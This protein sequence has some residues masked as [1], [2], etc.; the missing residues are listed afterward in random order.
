MLH[1]DYNALAAGDLNKGLVLLFHLAHFLVR[2]I[3]T[4]TLPGAPAYTSVPARRTLA[5][6]EASAPPTQPSTQSTKPVKVDWSPEVRA[7]VARAFMET[8]SCPGID[9]AAITE[10][11]K[12]ILTDAADNNVLHTINWSTYILPQ[13]M[14]QAERA[15]AF[16]MSPSHAQS[17]NNMAVAMNGTQISSAKKR[18]SSDMDT[19]TTTN[20]SLPPWRLKASANLA[21]R[22]TIPEKTEKRQKKVD[23]L[24]TGAPTSKSSDLEKRRQRFNLENSGPSSP[25]FTSSR[26][27]SPMPDAND[28]PVVGTCQKM[29]KNYFRLTAP[30]K[31]E[32]VRPLPV[33]KK[34]L[35][36]L[37]LKWKQE[38]NYGYVCD[39]FKSIR[40]DLTVQH[41]K[42]DFTVKVYESHA[43][44]ALERAD[45]GE[46]NQ[47][48]TQ[49]RALYKQKL[50]GNVE[51]F[52]AYRILY[53]IYTRNR[54]G[55]NDVL[56]DL[57]T[58]DKQIPAVRH[59]LDVRSALA[60][61]NFHRF[62]R[63]FTVAPNMGAYLI[64]T[65]IERERLAA[66][67]QICKA[68]VPICSTRRTS[69]DTFSSYK[70]QVKVEYLTEELAF[71][72]D[73]HCAQFLCDHGGEALL[74]SRPDGACF[75]SG[76][77]GQIF[78]MAK[79]KAFRSVDIKGQI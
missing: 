16:A 67:A 25:Y 33:L 7:Y 65:F 9:K 47:C 26:D 68:Y 71:D 75:L 37:I 6:P 32:T 46:Y 69:T 42:N 21:D 4:L 49:L 52:M 45:V 24:R 54:T 28:G 64:D 22:M 34:A 56:A 53:L 39:Q 79:G 30:P 5:R 63:L 31:A 20:S 11:L 2:D 35:E 74:Q 36:W 48:Q 23:E 14:I 51:E 40:Q 78:E 29:E 8:E 72:S 62:F 59:A 17:V 61:G 66:L 15:Q 13:A 60:S 55:M 44:I 43:R 41:I 12:T 50:G 58:A 73:Q 57:T 76:Q 70:P 27:D 19:L 3:L 1:H 38:H 18:K 77:A 10:K